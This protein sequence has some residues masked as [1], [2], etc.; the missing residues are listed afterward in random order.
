MT[1]LFDY[2][3]SHYPHRPGHRSGDTSRGAARAIHGRSKALQRMVLDALREHGPMATFELASV[4]DASYRAIQPR[5][6]ELRKM[7]E[8]VDSG[9]RRADPE[10]GRNAIVW[11][12]A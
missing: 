2:A 9:D 5:T 1:N 4:I 7:G 12:L 10:T 8:I 6:S 11:R 3:A